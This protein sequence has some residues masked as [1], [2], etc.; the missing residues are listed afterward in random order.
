LTD[1]GFD[2][3]PHGPEWRL[4]CRR[5]VGCE[6]PTHHTLSRRILGGRRTRYLEATIKGNGTTVWVT[7]RHRRALTRG[8]IRCNTT[9]YH[10]R[11]TG[12]EMLALEPPANF[13]RV[14][15]RRS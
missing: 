12:R 8:E 7:S 9:G 6:L 15:T 13:M 5:L 2:P 14:A 1:W 4:V 10:L 3:K 11:P